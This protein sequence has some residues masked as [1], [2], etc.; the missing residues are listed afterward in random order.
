MGELIGVI[1]VDRGSYKTFIVGI[2]FNGN[3]LP[4]FPGAGIINIL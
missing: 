3:L 1:I 4:L 2:L